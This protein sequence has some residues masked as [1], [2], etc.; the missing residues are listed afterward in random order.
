MDRI[1]NPTEVTQDSLQAHKSNRMS[2]ITMD[3]L[4]KAFIHIQA[5][6]VCLKEF[7]KAMVRL[8][9]PIKKVTASVPPRTKTIRLDLPSVATMSN[10]DK[11]RK[12]LLKDKLR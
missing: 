2:R 12:L 4:L 7:T 8:K 6:M 3:H 1:D 5:S 11:V 10:L 9:R